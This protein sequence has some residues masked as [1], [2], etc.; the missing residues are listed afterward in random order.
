MTDDHA[1]AGAPGS[2]PGSAAS[3]SPRRWRSTRR[4]RPSRRPAG[5]SSASAPASPTSRPRRPSWRPPRRPARDPRNHRYTPAAGLPELREAIAAK[6]ARDS[7]LRVAAGQVLVTNGGK[8]A[9]YQAFATLLDPGDEV[10]L[11]APYWT[12]YPEAI[13]LAGGVPVRAVRT[14]GRLP[15]VGRAARGRPH[16]ADE[17]AAVVLPVQPDRRGRPPRADRGHRPL[18]RRARRLGAHRRD[19]RAPGLRRRRARLDARRG[20]RAGRPLRGG[21]RRGQDLRDDRLAGRLD[22]RPADVV[23]AADNLQ[24][25][26]SSNVATSRSGPRWRPCPGRW[27]RSPRCGPRSTGAAGRSWSCSAIPGVAVPDP[28]RRVLRL[29]VGAGRARQGAARRAAA[30]H[31]SSWPRCAR[32]RRGRGRARRGVRHARLLPAVLRPRRRR[33]AHR[34]RSAWAPCWPRRA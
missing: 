33:P 6:T 27:T 26:L 2:P 12:T 8:Q 31:A 30:D 29:P 34:R 16:R 22:D 9:V 1:T 23:K 19:L 28:A 24:S 17:G 14:G 18:G 20:A 10:L 3:P 25:H 11:P 7:G 13:A 5:R 32:A 15:A 4:P 21:Q